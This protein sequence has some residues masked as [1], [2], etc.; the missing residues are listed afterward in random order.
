[1]SKYLF[2]SERIGFR[3]W[4]DSDLEELS[5]M[6]LDGKVMEFFPTRYSIEDS[7]QFIFGQQMN[8][9]ENGFCYFAVEKLSNKEFIGFIG[10]SE[11]L[12]ESDFTPAIDIGWR[13]KASAHGNGYATEG[14]KRCLDFGFNDLDINEI[15]SVS[16]KV[17]LPSI[18]VMKKLGMKFRE[19]FNHPKLEQD[20]YLERC[21]LY[22]V[23]K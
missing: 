19:E 17:N 4:L 11:Q 13:L 23:S 14:A 21:V 20:K 3:T 18:K 16:P 2:T 8:Y 6:N 9:N 10:L 12:W 15:I 5:K 7:K 22:K 1:M